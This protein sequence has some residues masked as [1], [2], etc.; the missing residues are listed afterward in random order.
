[1]GLSQHFL[2]AT[3]TRRQP[4]YMDAFAAARNYL[5]RTQS[6]TREQAGPVSIQQY[7]EIALQHVLTTATAW[8]GPR[9]YVQ[10]A[11]L[12]SAM[13]LRMGL[14]QTGCAIA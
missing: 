7:L 6:T 11:T 9:F 14:R 12:I 4:E 8:S 1:M 3:G 10:N 2:D 5:A 13:C